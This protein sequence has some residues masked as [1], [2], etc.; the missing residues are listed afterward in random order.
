MNVLGPIL[1]VLLLAAGVFVAIR[2]WH[3]P[4]TRIVTVVVGP[5]S[6]I[7]WLTSGAPASVEAGAVS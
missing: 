1:M 5:M 4:I 3:K 2:F 6:G 7:V